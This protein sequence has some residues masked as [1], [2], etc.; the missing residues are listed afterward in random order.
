MA[1]SHDS[2]REHVALPMVHV[3]SVQTPLNTQTKTLQTVT[4]TV[5]HATQ[6]KFDIHTNEIQTD[7]TVI[8]HSAHTHENG[9]QSAHF[10]VSVV[11]Y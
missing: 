3:K 8:T 7:E 6:T 11:L 10:F 9:P 5:V 4:T 2:P 1:S